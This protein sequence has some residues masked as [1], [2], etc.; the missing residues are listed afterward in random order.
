MSPLLPHSATTSSRARSCH[1]ICVP[2]R[3]HAHV[4]RVDVV[5][6]PAKKKVLHS[7]MI[8]GIPIL[9]RFF[10]LLFISPWLDAIMSPSKSVPYESA[11]CPIL[12]A[13]CKRSSMSFLRVRLMLRFSF[14]RVRLNALG[15]NLHPFFVCMH[16]DKSSKMLEKTK[17]QKMERYML[18]FQ[19]QKNNI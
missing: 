3:R 12:A 14:Q 16:L 17:K 10:W 19:F 18:I 1:S 6:W 2:S 8:S 13:D 11:P 7:P 5:S 15:I 4:R 9:D